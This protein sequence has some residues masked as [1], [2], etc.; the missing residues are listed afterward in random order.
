MTCRQDLRTLMLL[1]LV[2]ESSTPQRGNRFR[3]LA[4]FATVVGVLVFVSFGT[5]SAHIDS[6]VPNQLTAGGPAITL[7]LLGKDFDA[8]DTQRVL[9][10]GTR[11]VATLISD[12]ELQATIPAGLPVTSGTVLVTLEGF[13]SASFTINPPPTITTGSILPDGLL[14]H[15]YS[16]TLMRR[17]LS[18]LRIRRGP[19]QEV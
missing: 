3:R 17:S 8:L 7:K 10:N 11:V 13:N 5:A 6:L 15:P 2:K 14:G 1:G 19:Y 4:L 16:M 18:P 9:F 12:L